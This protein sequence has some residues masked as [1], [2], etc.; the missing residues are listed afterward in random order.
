MKKLSLAALLLLGCSLVRPAEEHTVEGKLRVGDLD[1]AYLLHLP[2]TILPNTPAALVLVFHGGG[3]HAKQM[4]HFSAF[5]A[6]SDRE[7]FIVCYPDGIEKNWNDGRV[8]EDSRAHRE[9]IDDVAFIDA[10]L[11]EIAK[12]HPVD[13]KRIYATGISN[14]AFFSNRL[15]AER[16]SRFA[17]IAPVVGGMAPTVAADFHPTDPVSVVIL[18]GVDDPLVPYDGGPIKFN[19]GQTVSTASTAR[20]WVEHDG[21]KEPVVEDLPDKDPDDGTRVKKTTWSGGRDGAEVVLYTIEGGGHTWPGGSQY[22][23]K[24]MIGRVCKDVDATPL[25]WDFFLRHPK[26]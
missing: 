22:L 12:K 24:V 5:S 25:I 3:G 6:L 2:P 18:Q 15:G 10:L 4:E 19:R 14:G 8:V 1:R 17:A 13:P 9:K 11:T 23:P 16:A 26:K 7:G 21:C 20:K